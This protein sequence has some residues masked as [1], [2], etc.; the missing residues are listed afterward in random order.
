MREGLSQSEGGVILVKEGHLRVR[1]GSSQ[2]EGG[3]SQGE[4][5]VILVRESHLRVMEGSSQGEGG[6]ISG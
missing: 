5:G 1:E 3:S 6:V 4:G 2:D